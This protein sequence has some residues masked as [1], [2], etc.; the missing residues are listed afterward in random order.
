MHLLPCSVAHKGIKK[1]ACFRHRVGFVAW[2]PIQIPYIEF[3]VH[4][5][6]QPKNPLYL[7]CERVLGFCGCVYLY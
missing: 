5:L 3:L 2:S 4:Y 1:G 6:L 7:T